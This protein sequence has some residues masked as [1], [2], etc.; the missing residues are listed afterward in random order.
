[1]V[2]SRASSVTISFK[3]TFETKTLNVMQEIDAVIFDLD[4]TLIH[5]SLD[6][7]AIRREVRC[8]ENRDLLQ[9]VANLPL[10]EQQV[11]YSIIDAHERR[12]AEESTWIKGARKFVLQ[13]IERKVP[14]AIVTRNSRTATQLKCKQNDIPINLILTREDA[15]AKPDPSALLLIANT[16]A[17]K[18]ER[19]AYI[20]DYLYDVQ[21]ANRA[22]MLSCLYIT[23]TYPKYAAQANIV[24][25]D[26]HELW[27]K[28]IFPATS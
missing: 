16:W 26:Y 11:A 2:R 28:L 4:G 3:S 10:R 8:P 13:L 18:P 20:G 24:F 15:P 6:F 12:D 25:R 23:T 9:F 22:N 19:I 27:N 1:M 17:S 5:S 21:A 14:I 7:K